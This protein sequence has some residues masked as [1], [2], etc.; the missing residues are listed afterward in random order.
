MQGAIVLIG[1]VIAC[2][3]LTV[4]ISA[5]CKGFVPRLTA[6]ATY[7]TE[8]PS[9]PQLRDHTAQAATTFI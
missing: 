5:I 4:C 8:T 6:V 1:I 2:C 3:V 9:P 7:R